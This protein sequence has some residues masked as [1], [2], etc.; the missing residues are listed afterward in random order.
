MRGLEAC[1][2][3]P[4]S[5]KDEIALKRIMGMRENNNNIFLILIF[6]IFIFLIVITCRHDEH[7]SGEPV[8]VVAVPEGLWLAQHLS[9]LH[10][11]LALR[12]V[13]C[14]SCAHSFCR[15]SFSALQ[16]SSLN[17]LIIIF[18]AFL[19]LLLV[20]VRLIRLAR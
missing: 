11:P 19:C 8:Q 5:L 9:A 13:R 20:D 18:C 17:K 12:E 3:T 1:Q 14:L 7:R 15:A 10:E 2:K 6:F 4:L 16:F